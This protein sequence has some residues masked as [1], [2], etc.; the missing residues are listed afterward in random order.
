MLASAISLAWKGMGACQVVTTMHGSMNT[1]HGMEHGWDYMSI[2]LDSRVILIN[3]LLPLPLDIVILYEPEL[4]H[5]NPFQPLLSSPT[6]K[7]TTALTKHP[8]SAMHHHLCMTTATHLHHTTTRHIMQHLPHRPIA[9]PFR[10]D[11]QPTY[12]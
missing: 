9:D 8:P 4:E 5:R 12:S 2:Q 3:T 1:R 7:P 10:H 6:P 11:N